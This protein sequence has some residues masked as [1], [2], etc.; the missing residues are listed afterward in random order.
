MNRRV[1]VCASALMLTA[2]VVFGGVQFTS[3]TR[4]EGPQATTLTVRGWAEGNS[5]RVEFVEGTLPMA[6]KDGYMITRDGGQTLFLVNPE[7]KTYAR[8]DLDAMLG[9]LGS[10]MQSIGPLVKI[11]FKDPKV[12]QL[13]S[14]PGEV[15]LGMP[16]TH[17]RFRTSYAMEMRIFGRRT[18]QSIVNDEEVWVTT[19]LGDMG[20]RAWLRKGPPKTG[21]PE[22]DKLIAAQWQMYEGFP[23]K[24]VTVA[25][26]T[27]DKGKSQTT[28]TVMEVTSLEV[29]SI[30]DSTFVIPA[31]YTET[32]LVPMAEGQQGE[33][34]AGENPLSRL[35]GGRKNR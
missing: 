29:T 32:Q 17:L 13:G 5:A 10:V 16:T 12:E 14:G 20:L 26:T 30:P 11:E 19:G 9:T 1:M 6:S 22:F 33:G 4:S 21:D 27:D 2:G 34:E 7:E 15:L 3:V 35:F 24:T 23:L 8:F 25:T 28:R 18:A 31:G